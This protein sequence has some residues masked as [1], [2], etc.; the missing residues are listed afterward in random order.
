METKHSG[1]S[2]QQYTTVDLQFYYARGIRG[3]IVKAVQRILGLRFAH[4]THVSVSIESDLYEM[5]F[6]S[7]TVCGL[8]PQVKAPHVVLWLTVP[9]PQVEFMLNAY[10]SLHTRGEFSL[11][12]GVTCSTFVCDVIG[13]GRHLTPAKLYETLHHDF[14]E[15]IRDTYSHRNS[16]GGGDDTIHTAPGERPSYA[17]DTRYDL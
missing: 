6:D 15:G 1:D 11:W 17:G 13:I 14:I 7:T 8:V 10:D 12:R 5:N 9:T 4:F 16:R 3:A 2:S